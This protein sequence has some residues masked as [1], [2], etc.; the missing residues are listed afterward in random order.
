MVPQDIILSYY[1]YCFENYIEVKII[2]FPC[3]SERLIIS[4]FNIVHL[5]VCPFLE[6][7]INLGFLID[8]S[9][10]VGEQNF[11]I[12]LDFMKNVYGAFW[13][14]FDSLHLGLM[15]FGTETRLIFGF[16]N[17]YTDMTE[18]NNA[19][20][21]VSFPGGKT[22]MIGEALKLTETHLFGSKHHDSYR[23]ILVVVM[24]STSED[25]VFIG[26]ELLKANTVKVFC[27]GV[28]NYYE[29]TQMDGIASQPSSDN[30]LT[31]VT[32]PSLASVTQTLID[33]I[34]EG[35]T[36]LYNKTIFG[37]YEKLSN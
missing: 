36:I 20:D 37:P 22:V 14:Q 30:V 9:D 18:I 16:D 13:T 19:I 4:N 3:S 12:S 8:G 6:A 31:V 26:A 33:K 27:V 1:I 29:R 24:G 25:D 5:P 17:K 21:S 23:R 10:N 15:V 7:K 28:G 11:R 2:H 32:Y 34:D 35:M